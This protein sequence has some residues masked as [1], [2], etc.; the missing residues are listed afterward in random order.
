M[1]CLVTISTFM[2]FQSYK[3]VKIT[4][5]I[6]YVKSCNLVYRNPHFRETQW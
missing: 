6:W 2:G 4:T 5:A 3:V 1:L